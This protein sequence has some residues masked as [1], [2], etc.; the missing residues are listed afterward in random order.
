MLSDDL[1]SIIDDDTVVLKPMMEDDMETYLTY[2]D[3]ISTTFDDYQ[4]DSQ[5]LDKESMA[6]YDHGQSDGA[7]SQETKSILSRVYGE[8]ADLMIPGRTTEYGIEIPDGYAQ[9]AAIFDTNGKLPYNLLDARIMNNQYGWSYAIHH[10][11]GSTSWF[12]PYAY[13][14]CRRLENN[15]RKGY[16]VGSALFPARVCVNGGSGN[17]SL[18]LIDAPVFAEPDYYAIERGATPIILVN[19]MDT[20]VYHE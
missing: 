13:D 16:Y 7:L 3:I 19:D 18:L 8:A 17:G 2:Y 5:R 15:R 1:P 6:S 4:H 12:T 14:E 9:F 20:S 10:Q 11:N